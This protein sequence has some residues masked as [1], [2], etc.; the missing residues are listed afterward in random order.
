LEKHPK[1]QKK[2]NEPHSTCERELATPEQKNAEYHLKHFIKTSLF[3][4]N[5]HFKSKLFHVLKVENQ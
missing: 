3:L 5:I 4:S 1:Y 2:N